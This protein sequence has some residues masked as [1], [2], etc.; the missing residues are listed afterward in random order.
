MIQAIDPLT[1]QLLHMQAGT[2]LSL[3][4]VLPVM[5]NTGHNTNL[6]AKSTKVQNLQQK[7][8][9]NHLQVALNLPQKVLLVRGRRQ[10]KRPSLY[11]SPRFLLRQEDRFLELTG[12]LVSNCEI[13]KRNL[14]QQNLLR[15]LWH[16]EESMKSSRT[17][18]N[19]VSFI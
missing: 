14:P 6:A 5:G 16:S 9:P 10:R 19:Y 13:L 4:T 17:W 3:P 1:P 18:L 11:T 7:E 12:A 2:K 15:W 8:P